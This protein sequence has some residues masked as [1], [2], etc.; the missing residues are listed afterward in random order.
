MPVQSVQADMG[1]SFLQ[2]H[3]PFPKQQILDSSKLEKFADDHF[4]FDENGEEFPKRRVNPVE[5]GEIAPYEQVPLFPV[6]SKD[7]Y[8]IHIHVKT[9]ACLGRG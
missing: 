3:Q 5:K 4:K 1:Q 9:R 8:L 2:R 6:F 7:L